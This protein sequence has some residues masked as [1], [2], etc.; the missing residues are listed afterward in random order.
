M[1]QSIIHPIKLMPHHQ[2][3]LKLAILCIS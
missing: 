2:P 1:P 3:A